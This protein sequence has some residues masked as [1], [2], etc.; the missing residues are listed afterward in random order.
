[1]KIRKLIGQ[2]R[3]FVLCALL[4]ALGAF[5]P[6]AFAADGIEGEPEGKAAPLAPAFL[7]FQRQGVRLSSSDFSSSSN[8]MAYGDIPSP[9]DR[10]HLAQNPP[11]PDL[12]EGSP[13]GENP[14]RRL[15]RDR[16]TPKYDL[17]DY[18]YLTNVRNQN[19]W[20]TCWAFAALG[21]MESNYLTKTKTA[22]NL[23]ELHLAYFVYGDTRSGKSFG[24]YDTTKDILDQGGNADQSIAFMSRLSGPTRGFQAGLST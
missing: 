24:T 9:I 15:R 5:L 21:G 16:A 6:C 20:G 11:D 10:S 23:A 12:A 3:R 19:P 18:G 4:I 13:W 14:V 7:A 17:R 1:M 2:A 8:E 22:L